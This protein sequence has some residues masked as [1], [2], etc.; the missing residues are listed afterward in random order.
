V[1]CPM[2]IPATTLAWGLVKDKNLALIPRLGPEISSPACL[3]VPPRLC[4]LTLCW[5]TNQR[6][7]FCC[8]TCLETPKA[9]SG[10][11]NG[12]AEPSL[13]SSSAISFPPIS[14]PLHVGRR[15]HSKPFGTA[16]PKGTLF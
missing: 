4:H 13:A 1:L 3:R 9:G 11:K 7:S 15:C 5:F 6:L 12:R 10:P 8:M 16:I 14:A 2:S